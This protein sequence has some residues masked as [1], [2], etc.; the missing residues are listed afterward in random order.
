MWRDKSSDS[1]IRRLAAKVVRIDR[2]VRVAS[3]DD[4]GRPPYPS[5]PEHLEWLQCEAKRLEIES[6]APA[7]IVRGRDL[8]V[9]GMKPSVEFGKILS[10]LYEDQLDGKFFT[11]EEA[12]E[13]FK[14]K[15]AAGEF[16]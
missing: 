3:A 12:I 4:L 11:L 16:A 15:Q 10:S 9:L 1:A 8:I 2:L 13:F 7:P 5:N 6:A 14:E